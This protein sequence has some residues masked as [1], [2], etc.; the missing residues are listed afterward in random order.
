MSPMRRQKKERTSR[1]QNNAGIRKQ[2]CVNELSGRYFLA[3]S[4]C[5]LRGIGTGNKK[6]QEW[7]V[8]LWEKSHRAACGRY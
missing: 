1:K 8:S 5:F 6:E 3:D 7:A 2:K 4:F